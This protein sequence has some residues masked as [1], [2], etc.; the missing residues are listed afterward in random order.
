MSEIAVLDWKLVG[1]TLD[2]IGPFQEQVTSFEFVDVMAREGEAAR[3]AN[4]YM[5][6]AKNGHGKTTILECI[7]G[8]FGLLADPPVGRFVDASSGRAQGDFLV[9]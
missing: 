1:L 9:R 8:L 7:H 2:Q 6:L 3:P 4:L 5:L